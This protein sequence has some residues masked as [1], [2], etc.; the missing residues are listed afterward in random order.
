MKYSFITLNKASV[1]CSTLQSKHEIVQR[2]RP[3]TQSV[4]DFTTVEL[5]EI[6]A[7]VIKHIHKCKKIY[8]SVISFKKKKGSLMCFH[9]TFRWWRDCNGYFLFYQ[10]NLTLPAFTAVWHISE[11]NIYKK[12]GLV[13]CNILQQ[14][15]DA[16]S[17]WFS[18]ALAR[19]E[20]R[21]QHQTF[22]HF[23]LSRSMENT[24]HQIRW[25]CR[26]TALRSSKCKV[27]YSLCENMKVETCKYFPPF[28][29]HV[30][31]LYLNWL[32]DV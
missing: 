31:S 17:A 13:L 28:S 32:R 19:T 12:T 26:I 24:Q 15:R 27:S 11:D 6:E 1:V 9:W 5:F 3:H 30:L 4:P 25:N 10:L 7:E 2:C 29:C 16:L 21:F 23:K 20:S 8:I 14:Q 18:E 22:L